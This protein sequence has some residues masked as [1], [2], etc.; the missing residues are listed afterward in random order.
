MTV[1]FRDRARMDL[2]GIADFIAADNPKRAESFVNEIIDRCL[3]IADRPYAA[4]TRPEIAEELRIVA[5]EGYLILYIVE[6]DDVLIL[7]VVH[8]ARDIANLEL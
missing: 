2:Q 8:G 6:D 4:R 3:L 7:R 1:A 5:Y